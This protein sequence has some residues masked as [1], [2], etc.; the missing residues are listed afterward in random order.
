MNPVSTAMIAI[1]KDRRGNK[2]GG[3][4]ARGGIQMNI[5]D[6]CMGP[7]TK[8]EYKTLLKK[9]I[10]QVLA[11]IEVNIVIH[12]TQGTINL[13]IDW[14]HKS[15]CVLLC[16]FHYKNKGGS[17]FNGRFLKKNGFAKIFFSLLNS[18]AKEALQPH[19]TLATRLVLTCK[20]AWG[21]WTSHPRYIAKLQ[22]SLRGPEKV[23][24]CRRPLSDALC[25]V[26]L[27]GQ[28]SSCL[29]SANAAWCWEETKQGTRQENQGGVSALLAWE[30]HP[31]KAAFV[32]KHFGVHRLA[33]P[34][35]SSAGK[36]PASPNLERLHSLACTL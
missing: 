9:Y 35:C 29:D 13:D 19:I 28:L 14:K 24:G 5:I 25:S 32:P 18:P 33:D 6:Y 27:P 17:K 31:N 3:K 7:I 20:V 10:K 12:L 34:T 16:A 1:N 11:Y 8:N 23:T 30:G 2:K 36:L 15:I 22:R 21:W 26:W 4:R